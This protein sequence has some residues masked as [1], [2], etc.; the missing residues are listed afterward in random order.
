MVT[1]FG[2]ELAQLGVN[3]WAGRPGQAAATDLVHLA[4]QALQTF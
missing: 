3:S 2:E 1:V 4:S